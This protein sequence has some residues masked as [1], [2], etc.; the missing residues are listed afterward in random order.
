M[1]RLSRRFFDV[2][3]SDLTAY[4]QAGNFNPAMF[5]GILET[6]PMEDFT[7]ILYNSS[8]DVR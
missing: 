2:L 4:V 3:G 5:A 7:R 8:T 1:I 6:I